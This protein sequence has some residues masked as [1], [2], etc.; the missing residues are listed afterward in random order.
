MKKKKKKMLLI[1]R[2]RERKNKD[3]ARTNPRKVCRTRIVREIIQ[4]N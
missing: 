4:N 2:F 1:A 3:D